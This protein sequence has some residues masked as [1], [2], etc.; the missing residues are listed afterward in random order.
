M[1]TSER[2]NSNLEDV[3]INVK[4]KLSVLWTTVTL[5]YLYGD[6]FE[7]YVP[8]KVEGLF[9][10]EHLLDNPVKLF[11]ASVLLAIPAAMVLLSI[12]VKPSLSKWLNILF[13]I[14]FTGIML[15]IAFTSFSPWRSFYVFY[16]LLESSITM[17]IVWYALKW[18]RQKET[19]H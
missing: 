8:Q 13:G 16:A 17:L 3:K 9:N 18:P 14:F 5:L 10:G 6:Y 15:L 4:I 11:L 1:R 19:N 2:I 12:L 7:L